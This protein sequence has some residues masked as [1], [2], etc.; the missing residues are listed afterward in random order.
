VARDPSF[1]MLYGDLKHGKTADALAAFP[2]A[3]YVAAPG[4]LGAAESPWGFPQPKAEDLGSFKE[5][6]EFAS[7]L[8]AGTIALVVDDATLIADRTAIHYRDVKHLGG[9]DL[10]GAVV[11]TAI[12]MRDTLRRKGCHVVMTAHSTPPY[13]EQGARQRGGPAFQGQAR[14]KIPAAADL[15][16]RAEER[17]GG[18]PGWPIIYRCG[19]HPD[20]LQGSRYNTPDPAPMNLGEIL[21]AAGFVIPRAKG[22]EWL[23]KVAD[24]LANALLEPGVISTPEQV[25]TILARV[26]AGVLKKFSKDPRHADWAL[27]D[28][29][30]RAVLRLAQASQRRGLWGI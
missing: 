1:S 2:T 27:R 6:G 12:K 14:K 11:N 26:H 13:M 30:D 20:Y 28:G 25:K 4:A 3:V 24:G 10:W 7:K 19:P 9:F 5:A 18:G 8:P 17:A 22:F 29:Y 23:D 21:R 16:L 15:L